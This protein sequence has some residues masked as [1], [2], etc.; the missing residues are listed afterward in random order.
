MDL[1]HTANLVWHNIVWQIP[2]QLKQS[3]TPAINKTRWT[4]RDGLSTLAAPK[5]ETGCQQKTEE[6]DESTVG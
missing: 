1:P 2:D 6:A 4:K 3:H 5:Q